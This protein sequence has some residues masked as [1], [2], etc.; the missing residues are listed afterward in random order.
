MLA[1]VFFALGVSAARALAAA[2]PVPVEIQVALFQ[3]I[4]AYDKTLPKADGIEVAVTDTGEDGKKVVAG[5]KALGLASKSIEATELASGEF[6][7]VYVLGTSVDTKLADALSAKGTLLISGDPG[8]VEKGIVAVA[9]DAIDAKPKIVV[10]LPRLKKT[11][12]QLAPDLLR[13][14]KIVQ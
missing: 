4:F 9:L 13:L 5:F 3:K 11:G 7:I 6:K 8:L 14:A 2:P 10:N 1:S 12:H